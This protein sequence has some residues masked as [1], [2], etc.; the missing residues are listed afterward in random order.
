MMVGILGGGLAHIR[1]ADGSHRMVDGLPRA[2]FAARPD[3]YRPVSDT[4]P[5]YL[6]VEAPQN[7][8]GPTAVAAPGALPVWCA[9]LE[10]F[11]TMPPAAVIR[12]AIPPA[13]PRSRA[14]P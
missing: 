11:V 1:L 8:F 4:L 3:R 7:T 6:D 10:R 2:P 9:P 12:P 5:D 14:T 13:C